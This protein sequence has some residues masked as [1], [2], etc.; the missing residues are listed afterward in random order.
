M[1]LTDYPSHPKG[2]CGVVPVQA[3]I[4]GQ[5]VAVVMM[6]LYGMRVDVEGEGCR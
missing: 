2:N 6:P 1:P 4:G 3:Q 5:V